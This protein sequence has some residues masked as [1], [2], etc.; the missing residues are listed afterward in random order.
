MKKYDSEIISKAKEA[1]SAEELITLAKENG[2]EITQEEAQA[3]FDKRGK[4][5]EISDDELDHVTGAG[6]SMC[7]TKDVHN[8]FDSCGDFVCVRC[9]GT[10]PNC[11]LS[12]RCCNCKYATRYT[13]ELIKCTR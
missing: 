12:K 5:G 2:I 4:A 11:T 6:V 1:K 10:D 8:K 9:G 3:Y 13:D 7:G